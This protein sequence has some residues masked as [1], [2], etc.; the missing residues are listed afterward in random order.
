MLG[1]GVCKTVDVRDVR[2]VDARARAT[3]TTVLRDQTCEAIGIVGE[4]G[5]QDR[6]R[7]ISVQCRIAGSIHF[8]PSTG[9]NAG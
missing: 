6:D 7:D 3:Q 1:A 9:A 8:P 4:G 5:K 2:M